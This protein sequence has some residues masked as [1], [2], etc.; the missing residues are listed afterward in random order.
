MFSPWG[1]RGEI[2]KTFHF[3]FDYIMWGIAWR[4]LYLMY[5]D[6][7]RYL[8]GKPVKNTVVTSKEHLANLV[9]NTNWD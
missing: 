7:S 3:S 4:N 9:K 6:Q 8:D 5:I 1:L 2:I